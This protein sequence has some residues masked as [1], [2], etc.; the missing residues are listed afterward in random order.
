[1]S[2]NTSMMTETVKQPQIYKTMSIKDKLISTFVGVRSNQQMTQEEDKTDFN[3][4]NPQGDTSI[5][6]IDRM[7]RS[8]PHVFKPGQVISPEKNA[9]NPQKDSA[10]FEIQDL[11]KTPKHV[12]GSKRHIVGRKKSIKHAKVS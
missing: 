9:D 6:Q 2:N 8:M 11:E 12:I 7:F 3:E 1:M 10:D 5:N 4:D